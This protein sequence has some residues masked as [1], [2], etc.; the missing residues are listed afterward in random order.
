MSKRKHRKR[1][2][3]LQEVL[4]QKCGAHPVI[5]NGHALV[6]IRDPGTTK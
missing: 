5:I 2:A 1:L 3:A 6:E 4:Q